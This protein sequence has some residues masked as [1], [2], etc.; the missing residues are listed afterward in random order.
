MCAD[1]KFWHEVLRLL[2]LVGVC[3]ELHTDRNLGW[4]SLRKPEQAQQGRRRR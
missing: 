3:E 4:C 2:P 1:C